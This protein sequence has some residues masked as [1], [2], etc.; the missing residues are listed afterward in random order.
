MRREGEHV[1]VLIPD[2]DVQMPRRLHGVG[3]EQDARLAA[4]R[5]DLRDGE[6]RADLIVGVHD[7]DEAGVVADG[8]THLPGGDGTGRADRQ[9]NGVVLKGGRKN[10]AFSFARAEHGGGAQRLIVGL[11]AA[12]GEDDLARLAAET[13]GDPLARVL[14]RLGGLLPD[15]MQA[16]RVSVMRFHVRQHRVDGRAA[17]F[18]G[19]RIVRINGHNIAPFR[20]G[21]RAAA[22]CLLLS[23]LL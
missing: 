7:R 11:A 15:R 3:V 17:H 8:V 12:G 4:D 9:Q 16:G 21:R 1:D 19:G 23:R 22:V 18:R 14:Q 5:A 13:G 6:N 2:V 10:V 20:R